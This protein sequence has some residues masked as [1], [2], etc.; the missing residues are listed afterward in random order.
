M[1]REA[2]VRICEGVG[3]RF[4]HATRLWQH[5]PW[6]VPPPVAA[7]HAPVIGAPSSR[8]AVPGIT[9]DS[10][11]EFFVLGFLTSSLARLKSVGSPTPPQKKRNCSDC[12]SRDKIRS[13]Y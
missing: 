11:M 1:S 10:L 5:V 9:P 7:A 4:P 2:H 12:Y 8:L 13:V 6:L 3:V